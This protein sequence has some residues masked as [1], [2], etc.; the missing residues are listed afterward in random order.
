MIQT[1]EPDYKHWD[2][3]YAKYINSLKLVWL[4]GDEQK[5]QGDIRLEPDK[6]FEPSQMMGG[7]FTKGAIQPS[8]ER[9]VGH[10][11]VPCEGSPHHVW[12]KILWVDVL[13]VDDEYG[14]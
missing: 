10:G 13:E 3:E 14:W 4:L 11:N 5:V 12:N 6:G 1:I 8:N 7:L 9:V 2:E